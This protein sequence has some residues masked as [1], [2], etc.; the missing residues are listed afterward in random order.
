LRLFREM[1]TTQRNVIASQAIMIAFDRRAASWPSSSRMWHGVFLLCW[2]RCL[3]RAALSSLGPTPQIPKVL[4]G[5]R[6]GTSITDD[7]NTSRH[8]L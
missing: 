4:T 3:S 1:T 7:G 8:P 5:R 6:P 2:T